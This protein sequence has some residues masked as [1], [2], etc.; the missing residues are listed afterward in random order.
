[1][2]SLLSRFKKFREQ[3][4]FFVGFILTLSATF[5]GV[6]LATDITNRNSK[7]QEEEKVI[8][9]LE[10][11]SIDLFNGIRNTD[12]LIKLKKFAT[13]SLQNVNLPLQRPEVFYQITQN[14]LI[15]STIS[16]KGIEQFSLSRANLKNI[17]STLKTN[18]ENEMRTL[19][20]YSDYLNYSR[21]IILLEKERLLSDLSVSKVLNKYET[22]VQ[23]LIK[24]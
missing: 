6:F 20:K 18:P 21:E 14:E 3:F 17:E 7:K 23:Q 11:S 13:D 2:L 15:L 5:I 24:Q 1:M 16:S 9:L 19:K 8:Q 10:A 22:L 12:V 4:H